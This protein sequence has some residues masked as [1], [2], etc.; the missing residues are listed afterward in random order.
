[1]YKLVE[2]YYQ[3]SLSRRILF[4]IVEWV[5]FAPIAYLWLMLLHAY[6]E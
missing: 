2:H 6:D 1:M 3:M 5:F 4:W